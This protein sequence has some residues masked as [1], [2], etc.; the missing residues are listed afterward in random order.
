MNSVSRNEID[1][2]SRNA[3]DSS[4]ELDGIFNNNNEQQINNN[5]Q[6]ESCLIWFED[7]LDSSAMATYDLRGLS[8]G[9]RSGD[10]DESSCAEF[11]VGMLR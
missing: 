8:D 1:L 2:V 6:L 10:G 5:N 4:G 3:V 11:S 9:D 7:L